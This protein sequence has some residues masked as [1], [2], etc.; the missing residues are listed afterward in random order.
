MKRLSILLATLSIAFLPFT[1]Y[2]QVDED[3]TGAWYMHF[4]STTFGDSQFGMQ[5]DIQYRNWNIM[6]DLEQL[7]LRGGFTFQPKDTPIK[8]TLGYGNYT[9]EREQLIGELTVD[10]IVAEIRQR[11]LREADAE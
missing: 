11:R 8:F 1:S 4:W 2:S 9:E 10:E 3:Q 7:L 5:G 6:G